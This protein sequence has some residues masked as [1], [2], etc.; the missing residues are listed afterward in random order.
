MQRLIYE[1]A[2]DKTIAEQDRT[3][4]EEIFNETLEEN[5]QSVAF[6]LIRSA[7]N[8]KGDLL[9]TCLI[10]NFG[11]GPFAI[12]D[13]V[14]AY[15]EDGVLIAEMAFTIPQVQLP[16]ETSMPWTFIFPKA[17]LKKEPAH[18]G[19]RLDFK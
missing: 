12:K 18:A 17:L 9:V 14:F 6:P 2:W 5:E 15:S 1:R 19:G 16:P 4:I 7:S 13:T 3:M 10:H 8:H 11:S